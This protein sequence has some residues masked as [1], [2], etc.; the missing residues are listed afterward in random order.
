MKLAARR[1]VGALAAR[2]TKQKRAVAL[3][4][5]LEPVLRVR[6]RVVDVWVVG[7]CDKKE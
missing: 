4:D 1:S 5:E 2:P 7:H 6:R 3:G